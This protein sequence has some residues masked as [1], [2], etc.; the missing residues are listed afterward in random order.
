[1]E[2]R[3]RAAFYARMW[4][5][6]PRENAFAYWR[7]WLRSDVG[8]L[9]PALRVPFLA[10]HALSANPD[11]AASKRDDLERRYGLAPMPPGGRVVFIEDSGHTIWEYQADAF[12]AALAEFVLGTATRTAVRR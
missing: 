1:M 6:P 7:D 12:D 2:D 11:R 3:D 9:L 4:L 8:I 5:M 10:I